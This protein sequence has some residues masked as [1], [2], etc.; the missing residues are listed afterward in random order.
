MRALEAGHHAL[1]TDSPITT[2]DDLPVLLAPAAGKIVALTSLTRRARR[3]GEVTGFFAARP[4]VLRLLPRLRLFC[5]SGAGSMPAGMSARL[6]RVLERIAEASAAAGV[7][8]G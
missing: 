7:G 4:A 2:A 8:A 6:D 3:S 5:G 1:G